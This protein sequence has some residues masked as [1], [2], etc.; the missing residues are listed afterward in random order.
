MS[1]ALSEKY[2]CYEFFGNSDPSALDDIGTLRYRVWQ[3]E[4]TP[5][6]ELEKL[7]PRKKW[8]DTLDQRS[9][10]WAI[11]DKNSGKL[12]ASARLLFC[13]NYQQLPYTNWYTHLTEQPQGTIGHLG[14]DVV[15]H[16]HRSQG[17]GY[18]L[19]IQREIK[20]KQLGIASLIADIP[21][22]RETSFARLGYRQIQSAK[23]GTILSQIEWAVVLKDLG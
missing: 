22:Y 5:Q 12:V 6:F 15:S 9:H 18:Y 4:G 23:P 17:L 8:I 1:L 21:H 13:E 20:A 7:A 16:E 3:A 10:H 11:V 19:N 14:R 2:Q